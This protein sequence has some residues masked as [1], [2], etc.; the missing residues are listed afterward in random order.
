MDK[1]DITVVIAARNE[2]ANLEACLATLGPAQRVVVVDSQSQDDTATIAESLGAE[3]VQFHWNGQYP[4]KRQWALD[5]L[6]FNTEWIMLLDA[7]ESIPPELWTEVRTALS[8]AKTHDAYLVR[9]QFH[10]MGRCFRFGGFSHTAVFLFRRGRAR[11]ENLLPDV[12]EELDMEVHERL[13]VEGSMGR[14]GHSLIH[15]DVKGLSAYLDRHNAYSTWEAAVRFQALSAGRY[16]VRA[17]RPRLF[18]NA[19]ER[20]R[21]LKLVAM[22]LP[23]EGWAWFLYHYVLCGGFLEGRRGL[24]AA[25]IRRAYIEQVRAKILEKRQANRKRPV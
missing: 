25:Q 21:F 20:R 14:F 19:Q 3:V 4:R 24:I 15:R 12:G 17:I 8:S 23:G 5:F 13:I 18:G 16:G 22:R 9:K 11:F 1:L 10:F 7:D 6:S 2:A